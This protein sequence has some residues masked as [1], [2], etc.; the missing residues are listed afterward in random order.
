MLVSDHPIDQHVNDLFYALSV[1]PEKSKTLFSILHFEETHCMGLNW[2]AAN[3][4]V[5]C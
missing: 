2:S 4:S 3:L 1:A 5:K